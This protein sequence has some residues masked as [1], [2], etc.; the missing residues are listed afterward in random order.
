MAFAS[1]Y[2]RAVRKELFRLCGVTAALL[3]IGVGIKARFALPIMAAAVPLSILLTCAIIL[4]SCLWE[5]RS[6]V[7]E[8]ARK[9]EIPFNAFANSSEYRE[10]L[11]RDA[12]KFIKRTLRL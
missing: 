8:E 10:F 7:R 3:V 4:P 6:V 12:P 1:E 2:F 11:K 5:W 9:R